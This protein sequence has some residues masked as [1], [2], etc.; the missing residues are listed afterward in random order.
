MLSVKKYSLPSKKASSLTTGCFRKGA[1]GGG[2]SDC[3]WTGSVSVSSDGWQ[4]GGQS[5]EG[6]VTGVSETGSEI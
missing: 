2:A 5:W 6:I 1:R 3:T 4:S